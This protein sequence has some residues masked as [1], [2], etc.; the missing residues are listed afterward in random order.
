MKDRNISIVE[1]LEVL[2]NEYIF[3]E[4]RKKIYPKKQDRDYY[5]KVLD[6]K[7]E[8]ILDISERNRIPCIFTTPDI[9]DKL[10]K[11]LI[12][13]FGFPNFTSKESNRRYYEVYDQRNYYRRESNFKFIIDTDIKI[14]ILKNVENDICIIESEG[15]LYHVSKNDCARII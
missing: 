8:K 7:K 11:R 10:M 6:S 12:P 9:K 13:M 5:Q 2:Q 1:Y 14:G 3:N 4:I 15:Q